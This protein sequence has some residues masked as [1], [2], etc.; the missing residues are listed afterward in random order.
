LLLEEVIATLDGEEEMLEAELRELD[1]LRY[2]REAL[3]KRR[4]SEPR[5]K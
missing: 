3:E 2:C 5:T 4:R 1:L